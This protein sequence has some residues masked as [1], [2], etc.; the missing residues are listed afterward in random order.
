METIVLACKSPTCP[1][2]GEAKDNGATPGGTAQCS[3]CKKC[4]RW[5]LSIGF[6]PDGEEYYHLEGIKIRP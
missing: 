1:M 3:E 4:F 5:E 2:D 6:D